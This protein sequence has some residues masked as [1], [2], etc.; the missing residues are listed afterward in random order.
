MFVFVDFLVLIRPLFVSSRQKFLLRRK[1]NGF[2]VDGIV[3]LV[4]V[5]LVFVVVLVGIVSLFHL[6]VFIVV[7]WHAVPYFF[8]F[9]Y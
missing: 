2:L 5:V 9:E 4:V 7:T 3:V 6:L 8:L 1:W